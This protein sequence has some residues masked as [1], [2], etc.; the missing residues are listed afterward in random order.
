MYRSVMI[1]QALILTVLDT[2]G[3]RVAGERV[4]NVLEKGTLVLG[5]TLDLGALGRVGAHT[6]VHPEKRE[7]HVRRKAGLL[8]AEGQLAL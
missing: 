7:A 1:I 4:A 6:Y 8:A 3:L 2:V 5:R